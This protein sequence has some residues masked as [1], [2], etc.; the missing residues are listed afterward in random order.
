MCE[1]CSCSDGQAWKRICKLKLK[2]ELQ[3]STFNFNTFRFKRPTSPFSDPRDLATENVHKFPSDEELSQRTLWLCFV[4]GLVWST[5][6]FACALPFY[7]LPTL[8]G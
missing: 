2:V 3:R 6:G 8:F 5:L 1:R 7:D 4:M